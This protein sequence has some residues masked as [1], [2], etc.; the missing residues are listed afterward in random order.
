LGRFSANSPGRAPEGEGLDARRTRTGKKKKKKRR[1]KRK[2]KKTRERKRKEK[3]SLTTAAPLHPC[4]GYLAAGR[5]VPLL[6]CAAWR[7]GGAAGG[8]SSAGSE[9]MRP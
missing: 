1:N 2:K 7:P 9:A 8:G 5:W 4:G 6:L 3:G